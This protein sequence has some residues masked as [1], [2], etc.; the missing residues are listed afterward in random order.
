[1][2]Y[3]HYAL[4]TICLEC[5]QPRLLLLSVE[6]SRAGEGL[7]AYPQPSDRVIWSDGR[8]LCRECGGDIAMDETLYAMTI[9]KTV[10]RATD[11]R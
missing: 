7:I 5:A 9:A 3:R 8:P 6:D 10:V 2:T 11:T 4:D 1:M